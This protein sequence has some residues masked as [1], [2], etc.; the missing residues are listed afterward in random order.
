MLRAYGRPD[1]FP[2]HLTIALLG[3]R[4][5]P[6]LPRDACRRICFALPGRGARGTRR[7]NGG[8]AGSE[9]SW[10]PRVG[11]GEGR[12]TMIFHGGWTRRDWRSRLDG[13]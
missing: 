9:H 5:R 1:W 4:T 12:C 2:W 3:Q 13:R 10:M 7:V 11:R 6:V 8:A